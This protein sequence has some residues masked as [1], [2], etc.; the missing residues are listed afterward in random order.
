MLIQRLTIN[1]ILSFNAASVE[2]GRLNVL[3]GPNAVGKSNLIEVIG[4][5]QSAPTNLT[6]AILRGGGVRQWIWL[7][8][9][10]DSRASGLTCD[11]EL[12]Q[13]HNPAPFRYDLEFREDMLGFGI[14]SE[15]ISE[16]QRQ[17][18]FR[19]I[20]RPSEVWTCC[21]EPD[22]RTG[23]HPPKLLQRINP[24]AVQE[25]NRPHSHYRNRQAILFH[26]NLSRVSNR[27]AF[28]RAPW[29]FHLGSE[30]RLSRRWRQPRNRSA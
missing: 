2:L 26:S 7:G 27:A 3:I 17:R 11:L 20:L 28:R 18:N 10:A 30:G 6:N 13:R 19:E 8:E 5:L 21:D 9:G 24:V 1:K 4:L 23:R 12:A 29:R 14:P 15:R 25:S 22:L 16:R